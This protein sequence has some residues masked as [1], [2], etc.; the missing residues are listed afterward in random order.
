MIANGD[1]PLFDRLVK[2]TNTEINI[3][4]A[5]DFLDFIERTDPDMAVIRNGDVEMYAHDTNIRAIRS[6]PNGYDWNYG[7]PAKGDGHEGDPCNSK[8][9]DTG[10]KLDTGL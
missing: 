7:L 1:L 6:E 3:E 4:N 5:D 9:E 8:K 2:L 10:C